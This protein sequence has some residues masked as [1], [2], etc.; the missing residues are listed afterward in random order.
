MRSITNVYSLG[1][2]LEKEDTGQ[3]ESGKDGCRTGGMQ[4][5][6]NAGK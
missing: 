3:E 2:M 6:K 4:E 5:R 1:G